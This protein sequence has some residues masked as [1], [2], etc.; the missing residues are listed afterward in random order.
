MPS[1][2]AGSRDTHDRVLPWV[3]VATG[4]LGQGIATAV[5]LALSLQKLE[6]SPARVFVLCGDSE[7]AEGSVWEAFEHAAYFG[8]N[9]LI[10]LIDVNGLGQR[11]PTMVGQQTGPYAER[12]RAFGWQA[13]EIDG[14]DLAQIDAAF[15]AAAAS[16]DRP[17][18][19]VART[20]KGR[21]LGAVEG[22]EGWHGRPL[23]DAD[24]ALAGLGVHPATAVA[25]LPPPVITA[26][27]AT[28]RE[29]RAAVLRTR[30]ADPNPAGLRRS[31]RRSRAG[32]RGRRRIGR[33][34]Q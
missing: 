21:G 13:L 30:R 1:S 3:D 23:A 7:M 15:R 25:P 10:V 17:T 33:R 5:G 27:Q 19:I 4:S 9:N 11:G 32:S 20:E 34:D 14:H 6:H 29:A 22:A 28:A 8:L 26:R 18:V 2:T 16:T 24:S 12:A 31:T